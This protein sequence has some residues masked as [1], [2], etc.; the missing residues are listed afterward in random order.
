MDY[1][2]VIKSHVPYHQVTP[3]YGTPVAA[4]VLYLALCGNTSRVSRLF[5][6][7]FGGSPRSRT[8]NLGVAVHCLS[9][10]AKEPDGTQR[11]SRTYVKGLEDPC[12]IRYT[13]RAYGGTPGTRTQ[14]IPVMSREHEPI[15]LKSR[16]W[17]EGLDSNQRSFPG[18]MCTQTLK[19]GV[20]VR[21]FGHFTTLPILATDERLE[22]PQL[23]RL[24]GFQD[25]GSTNYA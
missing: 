2:R 1:V 18:H 6:S 23:I 4:E 5:R 25:R 24:N 20:T 21:V 16:I 9:I 3:A 8:E 7:G 15:V 13:S 17:W 19:H 22:L 12:T 10:L 14:I 11:R